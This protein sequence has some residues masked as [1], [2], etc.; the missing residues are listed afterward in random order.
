MNHATHNVSLILQNAKLAP[1]QVLPTVN[2]MLRNLYRICTF[3][4]GDVSNVTFALCHK[5]LFSEGGSSVFSR[6]VGIHLCD[7]ICQNPET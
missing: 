4:H 2:T 6:N 7:N 1:E 3:K 5:N